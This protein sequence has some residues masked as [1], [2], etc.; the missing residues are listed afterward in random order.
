MSTNTLLSNAVNAHINKELTS[1]YLYRQL[2]ADA[3]YDDFPGYSYWF[4]T[5]YK[6]ELQ[7]AQK[8][9]NFQQSLRHRVEYFTLEDPQLQIMQLTIDSPLLDYMTTALNKEQE[10]SVF[11]QL[12]AQKAEQYKWWAYR[13]LLDWFIEEQVEEVEQC[14][15][16]IADLARA[17][18]N[19]A[20][21]LILDKKMGEQKLP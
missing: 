1:A 5:Q 10:L 19:F 17:Q 21:L 18:D 11:I 15:R 2:S 12:Q 20:A 16:A 13:E 7:H 9:I 8:L 3:D 4:H 14:Q 6:E